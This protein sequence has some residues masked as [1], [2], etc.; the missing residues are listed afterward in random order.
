ME[1]R[2]MEGYSPNSNQFGLPPGTNEHF[3]F[4]MVDAVKIKFLKPIF[5]EDFP[6]KGMIAWLTDIVL[7]EE[8]ECYKLYF[9]FTDF[10]KENDK[11][12]KAD[13][14]NGFSNPCLTAKDMG[15]Y[16]PK[17]SVYFG[18]ITW[19]EEKF[20]FELKKHIKHYSSHKKEDEI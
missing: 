17:Y 10:E 7:S 4:N 5:E 16:N 8:N 11:Y 1:K 20:N 2:N 9:D 14:Y 12:F 18:D 6:E 13:Y 15:L 3:S 19:D